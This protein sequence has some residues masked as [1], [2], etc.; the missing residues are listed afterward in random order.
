MKPD[1]LP[2]WRD[3]SQYHVDQSIDDWRWEFLRRND[4]FLQDVE[5]MP[6]EDQSDEWR[7]A[8]L[9][10]QR[11][12]LIMAPIPH[13]RDDLKERNVD[14]AILCRKHFTD[15]DPFAFIETPDSI[16]EDPFRYLPAYIDTHKPLEPQLKRIK[17]AAKEAQDWL[18]MKKVVS[19]S[20][21]TAAKSRKDLF[22]RYLRI[23]DAKLEKITDLEIAK[24]VIPE[25]MDDYDRA[26]QTVKAGYKACKNLVEGGYKYM[27]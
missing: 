15:T 3:E 8:S 13:P 18:I 20:E 10:L 19:K 5:G 24:V 14:V 6:Q 7:E 17:A 11:K 26:R 25:E 12:W 22:P 4:A 27:Y 21:L 16:Q 1:W 23:W 9:A 2:N